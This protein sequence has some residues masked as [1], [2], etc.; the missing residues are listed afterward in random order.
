MFKNKTVTT[1]TPLAFD[2]SMEDEMTL[3]TQIEILEEL[4]KFGVTTPTEIKAYM[5]EYDKYIGLVHSQAKTQ[6]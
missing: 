2:I 6:N 5:N 4:E 3:L 1:G